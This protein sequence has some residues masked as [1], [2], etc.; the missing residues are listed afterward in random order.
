MNWGG[1]GKKGT[2]PKISQTYPTIMKLGTVIHYLKIQKMYETN[3]TPLQ[4]C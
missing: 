3:D 2:L 4:F 1:G